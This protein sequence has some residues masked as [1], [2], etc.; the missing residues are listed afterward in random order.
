MTVDS[1]GD[2]DAPM[3][4]AVRVSQLGF[5]SLRWSIV[6]P[7][8]L[9]S[10]A[11]LVGL[12]LYVPHSIVAAETKAARQRA[13]ATAEQLLRLRSLYSDH[14]IAK[15]AGTREIIAQ[16]DH[17]D[18]PRTIPVPTTFILDYTAHLP[19]DG[20][21]IRLISPYPWPV[22]Q[23]RA[24][25]DAFE[26]EA[27]K[28]L[29]DRSES[30]FS[31]I[32][33]A[34]AGAV[35]RVAVADRMEQSCVNCHN[36]HPQSPIRGWKVGDVRGMIELKQPLAA[37]T[38]EAQGISRRLTFGVALAAL[39]LL[40]VILFVT[41]RMLRPLRDLA[42]VI[43]TLAEDKSATAIPHIG[44]RDELGI[45]ARAL[46]V[47]KGQRQQA[48]ALQQ[49]A[50]QQAE[51]RLARAAK[52]EL[53]AADFEKEL[54]RLRSEVASSSSAIRGAVEEVTTLS[55]AS[56]QMVAQAQQQA[57]RLDM[58]GSQVL[59][60]TEAVA[61]A[62]VNVEKHLD[63][64]GRRAGETVRRSRE[65]DALMR[66][67]A[68]DAS[69]IGDVVGVIRDVAEQT[70]LLALN[71]TI[72]AARAGEAG[73]GFAVVAAE[74]KQL[75]SR[76]STATTDIS[77]KIDAIQATTGDVAGSINAIMAGLVDEGE[78][79]EQLGR[80]LKEH[81]MVS[82]DVG[83]HMRAV[84]DEARSLIATL[85]RVRAEA[86]AT[87]E[88]VQALDEAS[89]RVDEAVGTLDRRAAAFSGELVAP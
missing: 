70:N 82:G 86:N 44:R 52:L 58:A 76:T 3:S 56:T 65:T 67:L 13:I 43:E 7:I 27:W 18:Q 80:S 32:E 46:T 6:L 39:L 23:G 53:F 64:A 19:K 36:A 1:A 66:R 30:S 20:N 38:A 78:T 37:I 49:A 42:G 77:V 11:L 12:S 83:H 17:L 22:R 87:R 16:A 55:A 48:L 84:F 51:A 69:R 62:V 74:V 2:A 21:E 45:V 4:G 33:G 68:E 73:R 89:R 47:L 26:A 63:M 72:E 57:D 25:F 79:A 71:A 31:R 24:P 14:V 34:G 40:G 60:R 61:A 85:D 81:V 9:A 8:F 41:M 5:R 29:S 59:A 88:N 50:A 10:A 75:A 54:N 28:A 35:L 15:M